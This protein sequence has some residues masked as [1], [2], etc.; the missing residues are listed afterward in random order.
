MKEEYNYKIR[1]RVSLKSNFKGET[2][3]DVT[4]EILEP[5]FSEKSNEEIKEE[6]MR[7]FSILKKGFQG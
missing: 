3:I 7:L 6:S 2:A 5:E 4:V 1:R